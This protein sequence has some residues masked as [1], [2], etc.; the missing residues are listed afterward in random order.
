MAPELISQSSQAEQAHEKNWYTVT[1]GPITR[2]KDRTAHTNTNS[3]ETILELTRRE[4]AWAIGPEETIQAVCQL[5]ALLS[6]GKI[7]FKHCS[8]P[9]QQQPA[10]SGGAAE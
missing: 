3:L 6:Y 1:A 2:V 5:D 4:D 8:W 7:I 10:Q 9:E